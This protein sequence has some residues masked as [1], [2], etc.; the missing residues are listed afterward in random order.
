MLCSLFSNALSL[1]Q[2]DYLDFSRPRE[3]QA[4]ARHYREI[5]AAC[6]NRAQDILLR[7]PK[8][9]IYTWEDRL[10]RWALGVRNALEAGDA[11]TPFPT[12]EWNLGAQTALEAGNE[13]PPF[14]TTA[15]ATPAGTDPAVE[16]GPQAREQAEQGGAVGSAVGSRH[17]EGD[18]DAALTGQVGIP[19]ARPSTAFATFTAA[20]F[21]RPAGNAS[22]SFEG[23]QVE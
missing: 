15:G 21:P 10:T 13:F 5:F 18:R 9:R 17:A 11:L 12:A 2:R 14:L 7:L 4:A 20:T 19:Q 1:P 23:G 16:S 8:R 3:C 6:A 22:P